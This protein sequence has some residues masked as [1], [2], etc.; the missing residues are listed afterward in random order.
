MLDLIHDIE[1]A[2]DNENIRCALGMALTLPDICGIVEFPECNKVEKRY[3]GWCDSYLFNQGFFPTCVIDVDNPTKKGEH[4]RAITGDMCYKLRCAYLH[5]GNLELN[6]REYDDFPVFHLQLTSSEENG[7]YMGKDS[8]DSTGKICDKHIDARHLIRVLC[9]AAKDYYN[10]SGN[11]DG[12]T[13][14]HIEILDIEYELQR[15]EASKIKFLKRQK[16]KAN[17]RSYDELSKEAKEICGL[18]VADEKETIIKMMDHN[19]DAVMALM[20]LL[21]GE[22]ISID[23]KHLLNAD[24]G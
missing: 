10:S 4:S 17:I 9:N 22:F 19:P 7:I 14:H 8:K 2:L 24:N 12:F 18:V 16:E 15:V 11:K 5:S 20:E 13:N 23:K 1:L 3:V 21:E 6:Q